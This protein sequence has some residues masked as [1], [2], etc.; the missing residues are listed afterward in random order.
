MEPRGS[1]PV[2]SGLLLKTYN[3]RNGLLGVAMLPAGRRVD[4]RCRKSSN[5]SC[6]FP[7]PVGCRTKV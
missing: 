3:L 6:A 2:A 1:I 4:V 5:A 7:A